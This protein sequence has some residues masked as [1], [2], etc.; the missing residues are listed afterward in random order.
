MT[1]E[2]IVNERQIKCSGELEDHPLVYYT[3]GKEDFV[4][5]GYCSIK[6]IYQEP[7]PS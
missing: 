5:C 6:Y 3:I 1:Q 2:V 4:I 7:T